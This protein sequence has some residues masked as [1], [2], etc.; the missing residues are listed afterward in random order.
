MTPLHLQRLL[1][2][3]GLSQRGAA[4]AIGINERHMRR[5]I[6]GEAKVSLTIELALRYVCER[7]AL[8]GAEKQP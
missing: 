8:P 6:A 7:R 3:A 4:K 5:L 1:D 2:K